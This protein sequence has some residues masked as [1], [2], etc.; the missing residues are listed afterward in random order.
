MFYVNGVNLK[1][2]D[3]NLLKNV[4]FMLT[5][6]DRTGLIG[7]NGAGKS[8]LFKIID[9]QITP[10]SG[11]IQ[12]PNGFSI[13]LLKQDLD[14]DLNKTVIQETKLAFERVETLKDDLQKTTQL[15]SDRED[16]QSDEYM[17]MV[18]HLT[19]INHQLDIL[20]AEQIEAECEKVLKGLGFKD[21]D[22]E[23]KIGTFSGG[24]QMR[25]ELAKL[26]LTN[27]DL[28]M[29]DEPTNHLDIES[30]IWLEE[31]LKSYPGIVLIISHDIQFLNNVC[32]KVIELELGKSTLYVGNYDKF[33]ERKA[34]Q[35]E[36][37]IAAYNNQ[38]KEIA[39]KEKTIARFMAKATKTS[40]AQSMQKQLDKVE[41]IE[42]P[43]EDN[44]KFNLNFGQA[45]RSGRVVMDIQHVDMSYGPKKV[46]SDLS[47][48]IE[49]GDKVAFVGQNGQGKSTL[50]KLV[51]GDLN[52]S[53][54]KIEWG[55][56]VYLSYYAQNQSE[57]LDTSNTV[58]G[59]MED[60][61]PAEQRS[62]IRNILGAF[63]FSGEDAEKKISVLSGGERARLALAI[64]ILKQSNLIIMDEPTN[65]LDIISKNVLKDALLRFHGTLIV[66][67]HDRDFLAGLTNKV[68]EFKNQNI[69]EYLGDINYFLEKKKMDDM[70]EIQTLKN[71][72]K[73]ATKIETGNEGIDRKEQKQ[74]KRRLQYVERDMEKVESKMKEIE[75]MMLDP[76]FYQNPEFEQKNQTYLNLKE[77]H[78]H[79]NLEWEELAEKIIE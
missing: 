3:R 60:L 20:G 16:Y 67:S 29:L 48:Y 54:G 19:E 66:V 58:L 39:D 59:L 11:T 78:E 22:F 24:W 72:H 55:A 53:N 44:K 68:Y 32:N 73:L 46:L 70:R 45:P 40:M 12:Y 10:D 13:G 15:L 42:I 1:F 56:N 25:V 50:A 57:T 6:K 63:L 37:L 71:K 65:H 52:P 62:N 14:F 4:D 41:R 79:L 47:I 21:E 8:T 77:K 76:A 49:R 18:N 74:L 51:V 5:K 34:A 75:Q 69:T 30:I 9:G 31:Y 17:E 26:L 33:K 7:K 38:Q 64:M 2:G 35:R 36:I 23:K 27:P 43:E 61:S 28:L